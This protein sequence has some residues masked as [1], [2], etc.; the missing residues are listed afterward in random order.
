MNKNE[1]IQKGNGMKKGI[2]HLFIGLPSL[3]MKTHNFQCYD[4]G[5]DFVFINYYRTEV[6][7]PKSISLSVENLP[8]AFYK[9][10]NRLQV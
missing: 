6:T 9:S 3:S 4:I 5:L 2:H 10:K 8:P 7:S 1:F